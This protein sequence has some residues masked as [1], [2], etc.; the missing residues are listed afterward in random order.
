MNAFQSGVRRYDLDWLRV[1]AFGLL[2]FYHIGMFYVT[3]GWHVKSP[4]AGPFAEPLMMLLNPW[5]LPLLFLISGVALRFAVDKAEAGFARRRFFRLFI[6]LMVGV[7]LVVPPQS[8]L[9]LLSNGEISTGFLV[10]YQKYIAADQRYSVILP[11][12]N[13]LWYVAYMLVYTLL[14]LPLMPLIR[15]CADAFDVVSVKDSFTAWRLLLL[16]GVLFVTYRFTTDIWFPEET[17]ALVDDWGAHVRYFSYFVIGILLAKH[18]GFWR[19]SATVRNSSAVLAVGFAVALSL[20][21]S[22]WSWVS[23]Q[24]AIVVVAQALRPL[25]AWTVIVAL[26]SFGQKYLNRPSA[27]LTYLTAAIFAFYILHQTIIVIAGVWL[28]RLGLPVVA[29]FVSLV[30]VTFGGCF[31]FYEYLIR[32]VRFLRPLFGVAIKR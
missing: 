32:R 19:A 29:E 13:H 15:Q 8:Y 22:N 6:P 7:F 16:P 26:L 4:H 24:S 31:I 28:G 21:W 25:Y 20:L 30:L 23:D 5:R 9:E 17:H 18:E 1:I 2:I 14:V 27:V 3:W 10:F 12:W 11:T